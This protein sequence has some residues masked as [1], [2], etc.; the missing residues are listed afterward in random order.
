MSTTKKSSNFEIFMKFD[1]LRFYLYKVDRNKLS[2]V[3]RNANDFKFYDKLLQDCHSQTMTA[4][5]KKLHNF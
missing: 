2:K 1:V 5:K 3:M 4:K